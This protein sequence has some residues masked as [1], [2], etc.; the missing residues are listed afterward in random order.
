MVARDKHISLVIRNKVV[1]KKMHAG[2]EINFLTQ[3]Y[4]AS[5]FPFSPIL[6]HSIILADWTLFNMP[7]GQIFQQNLQEN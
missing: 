6:K 7:S 3:S 4:I 5:V 1:G 2:G